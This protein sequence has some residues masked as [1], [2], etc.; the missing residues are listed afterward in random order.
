MTP[1]IVV[2]G[3]WAGLA[4]ASELVAAGVAVQLLEAAPQL[5][6]RARGLTL[7]S[8]SVDNG[9]HLLIG[10]Y[11]ETLRLLRR[12]GADPAGLYR[13]S[14]RLAV[15]RE[16]TL[17]QLSAPPLPAPL[18][19]AWALLR[20]R[21]LRPAERRAALRFCLRAWRQGFALARDI[22]VDQL[23]ADQPGGLMQALW[24]PLCLATLNT[25]P[26]QASAQVFLRVLHD[27]FTRRRRNADLLHPATDL[28]RLLP[29]PARRYI[30]DQ[31]GEVVT[32]C[33]V[34]TLD[35]T[36]SA[37]AV[38]TAHGPRRAG[39]IILATAPWHAAHLLAPHAP[40]LA[41]QLGALGAAPITTV[42][43][44]YPAGV[45]LG[46]SMLGL[47]GGLTQWLV[48]RG[49]VCGQAG[50]LAA[51]ISG[52]GPH[53]VLD[54]GQLGTQVAAEIGTRFPHWP[55]PQQVKVVREK[56]ATFLCDV[57]SNARRPDN[58]TALSR[59]WL[60]GDYTATG[61]PATLE[62]AVRSGVQCA[63][64]IIDLLR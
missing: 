24:E 26:A 42:Y 53:M 20:A 30:E 32:R 34:T 11:S 51:V 56:R 29:Q 28:G 4:A 7:D 2:G 52:P 17:V 10:A 41:Q 48:D 40:A 39:H 62:G 55:A 46:R 49:I 8:L 36:D 35:F 33:R 19:L 58:A 38:H 44:R 14:L 12:V 23:L 63:R 57:G 31:G 64:R 54:S 60:A 16:G 15:Q 13:E 27:A 43:L 47:A 21:G 1:V 37:A 59:L 6:G 5:G 22:S 50:L 9:Q 18:H 3:G 45:T 25:P 61:Y